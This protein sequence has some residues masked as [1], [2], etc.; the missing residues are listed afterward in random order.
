[1][2]TFGWVC[3]VVALLP[4]FG[5]VS[6]GKVKAA[7]LEI[8]SLKA[9]AAQERD[10]REA[11]T[12]VLEAERAQAFRERQQAEVE[13]TGEREAHRTVVDA[14]RAEKVVIQQRYDRL[15]E[16]TREAIISDKAVLLTRLKA[17]EG[18][19]EQSGEVNY[20]KGMFTVLTSLEYRGD[21]EIKEYPF[22]P[23]SYY[24][25]FQVKLFGNVLFSHPVETAR[26]EHPLIE[27]GK[28]LI[29]LAALKKLFPFPR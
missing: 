12:R 3:L 10:Q 22:W 17:C 20:Y 19:V 21:P 27:A 16:Q 1:M 8:E 29:D 25:R 2:K 15:Y 7:H 28:I 24:Y 14:L 11:A 26:A 4:G 13:R 9:R 23:D 5:C 18:D 6:T